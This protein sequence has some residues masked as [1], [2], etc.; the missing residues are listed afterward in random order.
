[1]R[2]KRDATDLV[3][4]FFLEQVRRKNDEGGG[5]DITTAQSLSS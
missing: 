3:S 1:M 2:D 4:L 5:D